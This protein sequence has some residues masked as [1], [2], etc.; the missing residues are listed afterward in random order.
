MKPETI[1]LAR[2]RI[3]RSE[4]ALAEGEDL[5]AKQRNAG[6]VTRF[7]YAAFHSAR[8]LLAVKGVDSARHSGLIHLFQEHYVRYGPMPAETARAL[9]RAYEKRQNAD[10]TDF[11]QVT[12]EDAQR[13]AQEVRLFV[14]ECMH[15]LEQLLGQAEQAP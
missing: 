6:A 1:T 3:T 11:I 10:Y 12:P 9:P 7:Y 2:Y 14:E 15:L 4:E 8:A 5:L 13:V